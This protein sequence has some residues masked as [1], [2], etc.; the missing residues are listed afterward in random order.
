[1]LLSEGRGLVALSEPVTIPAGR[2][3]LD[4][5]LVVPTRA[6]RVVLFAPGSGSSR[7]SPPQ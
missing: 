1:M 3:E 2:V 5:D 6:V 7:Q 4:G